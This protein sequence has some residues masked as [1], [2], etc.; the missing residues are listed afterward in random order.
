MML[1]RSVILI[2]EKASGGLRTSLESAFHSIDWDV[3]TIDYGPWSPKYVASAAFRIP[4]LG[5]LFE[6]QFKNKIDELVGKE[7]KDLVIFLTSSFIT[8]QTVEYLRK[9]FSSPIICWN[10]DS[11]FDD[12][13][14]NRG[15][16]QPRVIPAYDY[17]VTWSEDVAELIMPRNP[18]VLVIPFAWDPNLHFPV[19]G[20]GQAA[21]RV[22]FVGS[23]NRE[24][25]ELIERIK[26]FE[27]L[28]FGNQWP[29][30][31]GVEVKP[32]IYGETMAGIVGEAKWNLNILRRQNENSHNMRTFEVP[33]CG[34]NQ[35]TKLTKDHVRF[36]GKDTR[37][38]FYGSLSELCD[39]LDTNPDKL[40]PRDR[41][42]LDGHTYSDR[43]RELLKLVN[44][45]D[46]YNENNSRNSPTE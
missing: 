23:G 6:L 40:S 44:I 20:T 25:V 38:K 5:I 33:G 46:S 18:N 26:R 28:I 16:G 24:R 17:Y 42:V 27:P 43:V 1:K 29:E 15:A 34:G 36:L 22:V 19:Q 32:A 45:S 2:G 4:K 12:A 14:S 9:K 31:K 21:G 37:T 8:F 7:K 10:A 35:V 39:L 13:I 30:I 41:N 3:E 11:P